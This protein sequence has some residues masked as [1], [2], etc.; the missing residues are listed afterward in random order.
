MKV[1]LGQKN[2]RYI[3]RVLCML[4]V[5]AALL[6]VGCNYI[7]SG[8]I[9]TEW[10][11]RVEEIAVGA[12]GLFPSPELFMRTGIWENSMNSNLWFLI[13]GLLYRLSG[14]MVL[15]YRVYL[16]LIQVGTLFFSLMFF[17][18]FFDGEENGLSVC[19]GVLLYMT[20]PYRIF[21]CYD[22]ANLSLATAWMFLPLYAW[23]V[24]G[25][26]RKE[27]A[28]KNMAVAAFALAAVGYADTVSFLI[29]LGITLIAVLWF[30]KILPL[31][32][33]AMA[34]MLF[35]P[36]LYRLTV[37]LFSDGFQELE[38]PI[39]TIMQNGYRLGQFFSSYMYRDG[40]PGMGLGMMAGILAG[41]WMTFVN[42]GE[43]NCK[44][45]SDEKSTQEQ[46]I[47]DKKNHFEF[48][49]VMSVCL[50]LLS[51]RYFPWDMVQRLGGWSMKLVSLVDT[52]AVFGGLAM[53][54]LCIPAAG[55]MNLVETNE[56]R[57]VAYAVPMI[58]LLACLGVCVYQCNMLTYTRPILELF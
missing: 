23:A 12:P 20:C 45:K 37:Y 27:H 48:F 26:L 9:V 28:W 7:M 24:T 8:G 15:V 49:I 1:N 17:L 4:A 40:H 25:M 34:G 16:L 58:V 18:R 46:S 5:T 32:S 10:I 19:F 51:L 43:K 50:M 14:N 11:D 39:Q 31:V 29:I 3:C 22:W 35:L 38:L 52:P 42:G 47:P 21:V 33:A 44:D 41:L 57:T 54:C 55:S 6:P 30:Q 2:G 13:P 36:G 53:G 56:N